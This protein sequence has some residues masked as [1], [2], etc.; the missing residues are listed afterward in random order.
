MCRD[1]GRR[2]QRSLVERGSN[3]NLKKKRVYKRGDS[4]GQAR[5]WNMR[6]N[7]G[8]IGGK[9]EDEAPCGGMRK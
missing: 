3:K 6:G 9:W 8:R 5:T 1:E 7:Y 2:R 4:C